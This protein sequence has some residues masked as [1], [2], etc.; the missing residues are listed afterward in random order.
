MVEEKSKME[1]GR[2]IPESEDREFWFSTLVADDSHDY[3]VNK[4]F[5]RFVS[6]TH[7]ERRRVFPLSRIF[8][9]AAAVVLVLVVSSISYWYGRQQVES[10]FADVSVEAPL[11]AKTRLVLPDGSLVWLNAGS[12]IIYSQGFG[13]RDRNLWLN[14]EAYF[15]VEKN[16][17]LPFAVTTKELD[18]TVLGTK[19]NF[20]NYDDDEEVTVDLLEGKVQ[21][22]NHVKTMD[23]CYLSPSEKVTL[24]KQ[25]GD[26]VIIPSKTENVKEW[27]NDKLLF[28]EM[29][30]RDIVRELNRIYDVN[31][32]IMDDQL[33]DVCFYAQFDKKVHSIYHVL[34]IITATNRL[35]YK[36]EGDKILLYIK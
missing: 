29:P 22:E 23:K 18:V 19:F 2:F 21:L 15:E 17:K 1:N 10:Q 8:Y 25:T 6:R 33:A 26:M 30:L 7:K 34:D 20:R 27:T 28:D 4:A 24:N 5:D 16:E 31:I 3:D 13:V 12:K 11:G 36:M 9:G 14:G 32:C 35:E